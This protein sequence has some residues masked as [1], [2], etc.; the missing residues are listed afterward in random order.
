[1][2]PVRFTTRALGSPLLGWDPFRALDRVTRCFDA[3]CDGE[4]EP[5]VN[6]F[7]VDVREDENGYA[8]EAN[9]PGVDKETMD[10]TFEDG[11]LT[12]SA[13][14]RSD[15]E[16]NHGDFH[17]RER[18]VGRFSRSFRLPG[19]VDPE[20]VKAELADG[21][22]TVTVQKVEAQKPHKITVQAG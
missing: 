9:L 2:L 10:V 17:I 1:M 12:I 20:K 6:G 3:A 16:R 19:E 18:R 8:I 15:Q 5:V 21:V 11:V 14:G 4:P 7:E 13:E 22:L